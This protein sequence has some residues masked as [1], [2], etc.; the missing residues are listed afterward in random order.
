MKITVHPPG[1]RKSVSSFGNQ[2]K[3]K[4]TRVAE[5]PLL[6]SSIPGDGRQPDAPF[7]AHARHIFKQW[8]RLQKL[9]KRLIRDDEVVQFSKKDLPA[10]Q[11]QGQIY[12]LKERLLKAFKLNKEKH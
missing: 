6:S 11:H 12:L 2:P 10:Y 7:L 4:E 5:Q 3:R 1:V 8:A 9:P